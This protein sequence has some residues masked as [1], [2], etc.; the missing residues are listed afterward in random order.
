M[1][2]APSMSGFNGFILSAGLTPAQEIPTSGYGENEDSD[3]TQTVFVLL[4]QTTHEEKQ[5]KQ[6]TVFMT[7]DLKGQFTQKSFVLISC[8]SKHETKEECICVF[9]HVC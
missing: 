9:V 6:S 3:N 1:L 7:L 2:S 8:R 5:S 4:T